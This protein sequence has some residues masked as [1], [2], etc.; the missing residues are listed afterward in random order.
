MLI[1]LSP[2]Y[3]LRLSVGVDHIVS[4]LLVNVEFLC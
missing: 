2:F 1:R 4:I 3:W